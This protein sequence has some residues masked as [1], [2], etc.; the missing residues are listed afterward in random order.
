MKKNKIQKIAGGV[1][2]IIVL[3]LMSL[4][5]VFYYL[6]FKNFPISNNP[7]NWAQFGDYLN[8]TFM[9]LIALA[10]VIITFMLG[11]IAERRN[12]INLKIEQEKHRPLLNIDYWY[13][14]KKIQISMKNKG[15]GP[16]LIN[17][18]KVL[19]KNGEDVT[20]IYYILPPLYNLY[21][22][23][24]GNQNNKVLGVGEETNLLLF[25]LNDKKKEAKW[26][27]DIEDL[28]QVLKNLKIVV[29]YSDVYGNP[30]NYERDLR[31]FGRDEL[32]LKE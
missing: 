20:G 1:A 22:N 8:G 29:N 26:G 13:G 7:E 6:K 3:A 31:W 14:T 17:E 5:F 4:P 16:L 28:R 12:D 2:G 27:N 23:F 9:P 21:D 24:T 15:N 19:N 11:I 25:E 18:F 32:K 10:G 30:L